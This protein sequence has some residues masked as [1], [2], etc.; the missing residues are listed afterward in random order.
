M[1]SNYDRMAQASAACPHEGATHDAVAHEWDREEKIERHAVVR[2]T[3]VDVD[4]LVADVTGGR[5]VHLPNRSIT[6][7]VVETKVT[8]VHKRR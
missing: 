2:S 3:V 8:H 1:K 6:E 4:L 7:I 5:D